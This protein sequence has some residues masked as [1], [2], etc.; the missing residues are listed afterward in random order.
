[1]EREYTVKQL[2][3]LS[4]V[5]VRTL[6]WYDEIGLLRPARVT[7][8]GYRMYG[9]GEVD[10]L[11]GILFY[12]ALGVPLKDIAALMRA[13]S[14]DRL[15]A[16]EGHRRALL[17][18]RAHLDALLATL[19]KTIA[20]QKGEGTMT[21]SE[22]FAGFKQKLV[23]ENEKAYGSEVRKAYGDEAVDASNRK[24]LDLSEE[25][26]SAMQALEGQIKAALEAAVAAG[27]S[28]AG[29]EGARIAAL[30]RDWLGYT[31]AK[32]SPQAHKGLGQMY[33]AD[34]RFTAYYDAGTPG[35]AR[36]LCDAIQA[37]V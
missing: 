6:H 31:W 30:H 24:L 15:A 35:C 32:Y 2:A 5:T 16:L 3:R 33:V 37:H 17:Q 26:Y 18:Q 12:R 36:W 34:E 11:Q 29:P 23:D 19:D 4:G 27:E 25:Q 1:M 9:P 21:D 13:P 10:R 20:T 28:P 7:E 22:K 14:F 8:A